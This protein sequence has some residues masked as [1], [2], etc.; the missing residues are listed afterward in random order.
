MRVLTSGL[1]DTQPDI[2]ELADICRSASHFTPAKLEA[3][4]AVA[5]EGGVSAASRRLHI[6]QPALSQTINALER[7]LRVKLLERSNTGVRTT[8][9]GVILLTEARA[10]LAHHDRMLRALT[11]RSLEGIV[12][13]VCIPAELNPAVLQALAKFAADPTSSHV[14][15]RHLSLTEQLAE[16]RSGALDLSLTRERPVGPDFDSM[17]LTQDALGVQW[18]RFARS[19][20][21]R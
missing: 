21:P 9:Q 12:I 11:D 4:V 2:V 6:S 7:Q 15:V 17:L 8:P 16:L 18:I 14:R 10:F 1:T 5:E 20:S 19:N 3:F 13:S